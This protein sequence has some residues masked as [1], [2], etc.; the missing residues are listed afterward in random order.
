M[1]KPA[2]EIQVIDIIF[3]FVSEQDKY[4]GIKGPSPCTT[5]F[6]VVHV[7][8]REHGTSV[9]VLIMEDVMLRTLYKE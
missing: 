1:G 3:L 5:I 4:D 6:L 8:V 2:M 9:P 7:G